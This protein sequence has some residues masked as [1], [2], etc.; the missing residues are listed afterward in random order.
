VGWRL[1]A[2]VLLVLH[3]D[4][5]DEPGMASWPLISEVYA[6]P[7][8]PRPLA[9]PAH[10][11]W[12][13]AVLSD[14]HAPN[15]GHMW[16][17]I[18][19]TVAALVAMHVRAVVITGDFTNGAS[20][21]G[22]AR[23]ANAAKL[24]K[25][26]RAALS[27]LRAAGIAVLPVAGNHDSY[28]PGHRALYAKAF[29]DLADWARPF[30]IHGHGDGVSLVGP[31][32]SYGVD[33]DDVHFTLAHL[34]D[35]RPHPEIES[36]IASDLDAAKSAKLR[37]VFGHVPM[38][39]IAVDT[40]AGYLTRLGAIF[41]HGHADVAVFGHEHLVWDEN[42]SLPTGGSV[43]EVLVG[44]TSGFYNYGPSKASM[45]RAHCAS[46]SYGGHADAQRCTMPNGGGTFVLAHGR[47]GRLLQHARATFTI[48]TV[49]GAHV[50]AT[51]MTLDPKGRP[52]P[53]YL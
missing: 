11:A 21:D 48:F 25:A 26:I 42:V 7:A 49:D 5:F 30:K 15:D 35:R 40:S 24:W 10:K 33:I 41:T 9:K 45:K 46:T 14:I 13:F 37:F 31:P 17:A 50:K 3:P 1:L 8:P 32:F 27:P 36:W 29:T 52:I 34:V 38:S 16:P 44:C 43:R 22:S 28:L 18:D 39:S 53:F 19:R 12:S 2:L 23:V 6:A 47:K 4:S 51:P 20:T